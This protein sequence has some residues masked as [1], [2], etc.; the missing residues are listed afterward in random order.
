VFKIE[1]R[2]AC[3]GLLFNK[4]TKK[5]GDMSKKSKFF[6][7]LGVF[8]FAYFMLFDSP[9]VR[10]AILDMFSMLQDYIRKHI[11]LCLVPSFFIVGA[12][13]VFISQNA[14]MKY[15]RVEANKII[16][17]GGSIS[18]CTFLPLFSKTAFGEEKIAVSNDS[19]KVKKKLPKLVDFGSGK[20]IPCKMMFPVLDVLKKKYKGKLEV[21]FMDIGK[22][23]VEAKK[24]GIKLIPTQ[25]IYS[26]K[27][28]E[29]YRHEGYIPQE[30]LEK[31]LL[32]VGIK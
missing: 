10:Y 20:C 1:C 23:Y 5:G 30:Q 18:S 17:Y 22:H 32:K 14:V 21:V 26:F 2:F 7:I 15:L 8:L 24:C 19:E 11:L 25:I 16:A 9:R 13:S 6:I 3:V 29:V 12:I 31:Q 27:G 28:K 4:P